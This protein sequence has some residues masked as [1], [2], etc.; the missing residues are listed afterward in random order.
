M[1]DNK[2]VALE[3]LVSIAEKEVGVIETP[4]KN[5]TG[6]DIVKYQ[7]ATWLTPAAWSWCAAFMCWILRE[8][9]SLPNVQRILKLNTPKEIQAWRCRDASAFGWEKWATK[10]KLPI[11]P[12]TSLAKKGDIVIFDFSHIGIVVEN[13]ATLSSPIKTIEG[14]TNGSGDRDS[15]KGDGVWRKSR[16][17]SLTKCY[18][19]IL[20]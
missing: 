13:Q 1:D 19:R 8:W 6:K 15:V 5:N 14:N 9:L 17:P 10:N 3:M 11:L 20:Q 12:E 2:K 7:E 16:T 18:I 4:E